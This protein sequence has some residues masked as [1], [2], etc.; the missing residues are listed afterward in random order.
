MKNGR[1]PGPGNSN[2]DRLATEGRACLES[3]YYE[4]TLKLFSEAA[5]VSVEHADLHG[6]VVY[7][8]GI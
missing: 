2:A 1:T 4:R 6:Q 3:R 7:L 5:K 8:A